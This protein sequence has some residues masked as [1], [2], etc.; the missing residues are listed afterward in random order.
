M[1]GL[2]AWAGMI[3]QADVKA[4]DQVFIPAVTGGVGLAAA[5]YCKNRG[6]TVIGLAG[7]DEKCRFAVDEL[8]IHACINRKSEDVEQRLGELFPNGIDVYFD[9]IGG[10]LLIQV[11]RKLA[12]NARVILCGLMAEY[13][14]A[15][16]SPGPPPGNWIGARAIVYGLVVYDYEH[17][18]NEFIEA[19]LPDLKTGKLFQREE[20]NQGIESAARAFCRLMRGENFGKVIVAF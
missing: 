4:G 10:E 7:S 20:I 17:R 12:I 16:R 6:A 2:T 19:C 18:R 14:N 13:N 11:S 9:L 15:E 1:T 5:Q 8:G 3:W